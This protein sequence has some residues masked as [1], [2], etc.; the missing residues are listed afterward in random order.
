MGDYIC[1]VLRCNEPLI[2]WQMEQPILFFIKY[3]NVTDVMSQGQMLLALIIYYYYYMVH[4]VIIEPCG[5][6][7]SHQALVL[8]AVI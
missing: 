4:D 3:V 7:G 1:E 6:Q 5:Y 2:S 8:W